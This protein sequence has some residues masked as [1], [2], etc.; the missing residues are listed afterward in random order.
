MVSKQVQAVKR[1]KHPR[2]ESDPFPHLYPLSIPFHGGSAG[3]I[4]PQRA[5]M[6]GTVRSFDPAIRDMLQGRV[7]AVAEGIAASYGATATVK[8]RR[9]FPPV[10]NHEHETE[11]A[12]RVASVV[13][14]PGNV[15][16][17]KPPL[18]GSEDFAFML[19][20]RPGNIMLIGGGATA[21][22]HAATGTVTNMT[23]RSSHRD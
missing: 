1:G 16:A 6:V 2:D 12:V 8:Y 9:M 7:V 14:G 20:R 15:Q 10:V 22:L 3:N 17:D 11:L 18:M 21:A 4:I 23:Q 5:E 13:V 19:E